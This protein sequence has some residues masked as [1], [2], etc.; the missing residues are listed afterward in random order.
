M[1]MYIGGKIMNDLIVF[2]GDT[3][4]LNAEVSKQIAEFEKIIKKIKKAEDDLKEKILE[5]ME[6]CEIVKIDTDDITINYVA[7]TDRETFDS[8]RFKAEHQD[9]YDNYVKMSPVKASVRVKVK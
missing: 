2:D 1:K 5:S 8:K 3:P 4:V 7:P 6:E 9:I